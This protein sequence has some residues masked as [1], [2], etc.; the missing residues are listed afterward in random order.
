MAHNE[1]TV[2][3][4]TKITTP[5]GYTHSIT[6]RQRATEADIKTQLANI[7]RLDAAFRQMNWQPAE[8]GRRQATGHGNGSQPPAAG[9]GNGSQPKEI[10][11][12]DCQSLACTI[13]GGKQYWKISDASHRW[14]YP[15]MIYPEVLQKYFSMDKLEP[16][17]IY[18]LNGWKAVFER[19][20]K[21]YPKKIISLTRPGEA[22]EQPQQIQRTAEPPL[23]PEAQML[24]HSD[25]ERYAAHLAARN[26]TPQPVEDEIPF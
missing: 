15:V 20:D 17:V 1:A 6:I 18:Q 24:Q 12:F 26:G 23:P 7:S 4:F 10:D 8:G 9:N 22:P 14:K 11:I 13:D 2:L 5:A 19:N 25:P 3:S 21:G 16:T